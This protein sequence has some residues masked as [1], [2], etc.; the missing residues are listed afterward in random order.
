MKIISISLILVLLTSCTNTKT[1][2]CSITKDPFEV[3]YLFWHDAEVIK[4]ANIQI[5]IEKSA[6]DN[7]EKLITEYLEYYDSYQIFDDHIIIYQDIDLDIEGFYHMSKTIEHLE[8]KGYS[9]G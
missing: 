4:R 5:K 6:F 1:K 7:D 3:T 9:C 2:T 8:V